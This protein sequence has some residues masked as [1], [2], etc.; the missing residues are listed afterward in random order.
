ML[1]ITAAAA[2]FSRRRTR[3]RLTAVPIFLV[4]V[5]PTLAPIGAFFGVDIDARLA[6]E[7]LLDALIYDAY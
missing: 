6:D 1:G 7:G 5:N 2:A 4:T 3:L